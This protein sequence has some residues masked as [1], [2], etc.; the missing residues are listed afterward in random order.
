VCCELVIPG[1]YWVRLRRPLE[2]KST[3]LSINQ[4]DRLHYINGLGVGVEPVT[5][6]TLS[7][8]RT[9]GSLVQFSLEAWMSVCVYSVC[10]VLCA[11]GSLVND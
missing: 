10:V 8:A 4:T 3:A 2:C 7:E 11:D 9:V 1:K 5:V 6:A